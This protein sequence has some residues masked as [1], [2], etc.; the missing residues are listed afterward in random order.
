MN[1]FKYEVGKSFKDVT[2]PVFEIKKFE[3]E[4]KPKTY[5]IVDWEYIHPKKEN[6][7]YYYNPLIHKTDIGVLRNSSYTC[8]SC[9]MYVLEDTEENRSKFIE[10]VTEKLNES[11]SNIRETLGKYI[12]YCDNIK[13]S[14][15]SS[16]GR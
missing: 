5:K 6:K 15:F 9:S 7:F 11:I 4:E 8:Y 12:G 10:A 13:L 1:L 2:Q 16:L 3:V 14:D